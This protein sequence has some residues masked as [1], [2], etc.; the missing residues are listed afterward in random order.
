MSIEPNLRSFES[1]WNGVPYGYGTL[2][3][4]P[5]SR[6]P[7]DTLNAVSRPQPIRNKDRGSG[8]SGRRKRN[9][10]KAAT[11]SELWEMLGDWWGELP[12]FIE[13]LAGLLAAPFKILGWLFLKTR[14]RL[15]LV[16][17]L[18]LF[19]FSLL[20]IP[21]VTHT[22]CGSPRRAEGEQLLGAARD[23]LRVEY[24][25]TGEFTR[26]TEP[27]KLAVRKGEFEGM[28][29][30]VSLLVVPTGEDGARIYVCPKNPEDGIG[31]MDFEW[32]SG[33][34]NIHWEREWNPH[35]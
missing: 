8:R 7:G 19:V 29:F 16:I 18:M 31:Y 24:S 28:Y 3:A 27:F 4:P 34:S 15:V 22:S 23:R 13:A 30:G 1:N 33:S 32:G 11:F 5:I 2:P 26:S 14:L 25:K 21:L 10:L 20:V 17:V 35:R 9:W 6:P 12:S